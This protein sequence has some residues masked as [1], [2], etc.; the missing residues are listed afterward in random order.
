MPRRK[1]ISTQLARFTNEGQSI[2]G[3]LTIKETQTINGKE[4][5]R[6]VLKNDV[7]TMILNGTVQLDEA[8]VN[9]EVGDMIEVVYLG[10]F[11]TSNGFKVRGFEVYIL[12]ESEDDAKE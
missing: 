7:A 10:E 2:T 6:Y 11:P 3:L 1:M 5:G 9:A 4:I 8:F 12:E